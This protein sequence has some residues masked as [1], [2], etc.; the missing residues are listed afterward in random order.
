MWVFAVG[1]VLHCGHHLYKLFSMYQILLPS[2][3]QNLHL[4]FVYWN[5]HKYDMH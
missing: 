3:L 1:T 5:L 2:M 4:V